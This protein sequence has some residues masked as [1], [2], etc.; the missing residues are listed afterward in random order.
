MLKVYMVS[1][2]SGTDIHNTSDLSP[3][4]PLDIQCPRRTEDLEGHA[5]HPAFFDVLLSEIFD[6][7]T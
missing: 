6:I 5:S 1:L 3:P 4:K 7:E 2:L